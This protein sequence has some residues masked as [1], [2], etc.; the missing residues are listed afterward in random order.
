MPFSF[1]IVFPILA[2]LLSFAAIGAL[3]SGVRLLPADVPNE[4]SLH[5]TPVP[6]GGGIV[7]ALIFLLALAC[8]F[9]LVPGSRTAGLYSLFAGSFAMSLLGWLDDL[10]TLPAVHRLL[11][12]SV[13]AGIVCAFGA[14]HRVDFFGLVEFSGPTALVLQTLWILTCI[15]F[16][17]FMDGLDGLATQQAVFIA[18]VSG[19]VLALDAGRLEPGS[20]RTAYET[21]SL[22]AFVLAAALLGFLAFNFPPARIFMGDAGS[23]FLGF[24][25]GFLLLPF[26]PTDLVPDVPWDALGGFESVRFSVLRAD[27]GAGSVGL[28]SDQFLLALLWTPFLLDPALTLLRRLRRRKNILR[29]HREHVYQLL[30]RFADGWTRAR[31]NAL[32]LAVNFAMLGPV[33]LKVLGYSNAQVWLSALPPVL[34]LVIAHSMI[35]NALGPKRSEPEET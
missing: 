28:A 13:I 33:I 3:L 1:Q 8:V 11:V 23:H 12:E 21:A 18:A 26:P 34:V 9:V 32:Y 19:I 5:A 6:R 29:P 27:T 7:F 17:N 15:N 22:A 25:L 16:F 10:Y 4:R 35:G 24:A 20:V 14:P 2:F 30:V 31:V